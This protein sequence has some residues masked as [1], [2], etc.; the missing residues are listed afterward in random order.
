VLQTCPAQ[1]LTVKR[2]EIRLT[3]GVRRHAV[4]MDTL[5][6]EGRR[7]RRR[8]M[9]CGGR[10]VLELGTLVAG[11]GALCR[12]AAVLNRRALPWTSQMEETLDGLIDDCMMCLEAQFHAMERGHHRDNP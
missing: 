2:E 11:A 12:A 3:E 1:F 8:R 9:Q 5:D 10:A 7:P 4:F 6:P